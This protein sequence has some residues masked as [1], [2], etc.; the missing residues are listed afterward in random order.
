MA[1]GRSN[2]MFRPLSEEEVRNMLIN[3][4]VHDAM[5]YEEDPYEDDDWY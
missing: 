2:K 3:Y 4:M 1:R 5:K